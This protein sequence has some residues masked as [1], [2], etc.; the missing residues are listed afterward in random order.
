MPGVSLG[1][2]HSLEIQPC[3]RTRRSPFSASSPLSSRRHAASQ[4]PRSG[5]LRSLSRSLSSRS[6]GQDAQ[7][8]CHLRFRGFRRAVSCGFY[9]P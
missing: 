2:N 3:A 8:G 1:L 6:S 4:V 5:S 7:R 9:E